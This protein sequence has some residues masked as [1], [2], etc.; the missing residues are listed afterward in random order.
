VRQLEDPFVSHVSL[1]GI[2]V[3]EELVVLCHQQLM[4]ARQM[5]FPDAEEFVLE[6][7]NCV[8]GDLI[9]NVPGNMGSEN[10]GNK[11]VLRN[12]ESRHKI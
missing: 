10:E 11:I 1:D 7:G 9:G 5:L 3:R 12:R 8:K 4:V 2:D 6:I